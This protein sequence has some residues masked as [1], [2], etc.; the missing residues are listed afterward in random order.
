[1]GEILT[2]LILR[3]S[4]KW[5]WNDTDVVILLSLGKLFHNPAALIVTN[6]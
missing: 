4:I 1:M 3:N 2:Q 6:C 5:F